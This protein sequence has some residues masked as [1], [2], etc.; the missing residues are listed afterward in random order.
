LNGGPCQPGTIRM[1]K[2]GP[3]ILSRSRVIGFV[4]I[5]AQYCFCP[6][7]FYQ[8]MPRRPG[9][10]EALNEFVVVAKAAG[11]DGL[12]ATSGLCSSRRQRDVFGKAGA[13]SRNSPR[14]FSFHLPGISAGGGGYLIS[15]ASMS[16]FGRQ[17]PVKLEDTL[18][19]SL[20]FDVFVRPDMTVVWLNTCI[21]VRGPCVDMSRNNQVR[22]LVRKY[23]GLLKPRTTVR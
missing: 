2:S 23:V 7:C 12:R 15:R 8:S 4:V 19:A 5:R 13:R 20:V 10:A 21:R 3:T 1:P 18:S 22:D 14:L 11:V 6:E 16:I 17:N 9:E